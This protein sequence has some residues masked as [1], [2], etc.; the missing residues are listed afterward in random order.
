MFLVCFGLY[1]NVVSVSMRFHVTLCICEYI[2]K[3]SVYLLFE[4]PE[5]CVLGKGRT[6][7]SK[8]T[9]QRTNKLI[10][11]E[12]YIQVEKLVQIKYQITYK[13]IHNIRQTTAMN[14]IAQ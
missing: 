7:Q 14:T 12:H 6:F 4:L 2:L 9:E 1:T 3:Y 8:E 10:C 5:N 11:K 13:I